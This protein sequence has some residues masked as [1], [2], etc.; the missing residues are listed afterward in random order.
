MED[1]RFLRIITIGLILVAFAIG[2]FLISG[3]FAAL[4]N[5]AP[6]DEVVQIVP[7]TPQPVPTATPQILG[8]NTPTP[9]PTAYNMVADRTQGQTQV[10]PKTGFPAFLIGVFSLGAIISG[11]GLRKF[12]K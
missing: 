8:Q 7:G 6:Q 10:L 11:L 9:T 4:R 3:R 2:Y 1:G 12:P 5:Q